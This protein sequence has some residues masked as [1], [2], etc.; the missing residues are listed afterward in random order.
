MEASPNSRLS[1]HGREECLNVKQGRGRF[2][3]FLWLRFPGCYNGVER[4]AFAGRQS[5]CGSA[6]GSTPEKI[7]QSTWR[8]K[9]ERKPLWGSSSAFLCLLIFS[10]LLG[11]A[12]DDGDDDPE[13]DSIALLSCYHESFAARGLNDQSDLTLEQYK[14]MDFPTGSPGADALEACGN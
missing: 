6:G 12:D 3:E 13:G 5:V 10:A 2:A 1:L 7:S 8:Q 4:S 9:G 14:A 11:C